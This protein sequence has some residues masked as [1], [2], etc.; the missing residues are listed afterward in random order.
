MN[1]MIVKFTFAAN[2]TTSWRESHLSIRPSNHFGT[3]PLAS[4][5]L[6]VLPFFP[7]HWTGRS[8]PTWTH[9]APDRHWIGCWLKPFSAY[10]P[11][12]DGSIS[13]RDLDNLSL[14]N[15][16]GSWTTCYLLGSFIHELA[17]KRVRSIN[18]SH[19][20]IDGGNVFLWGPFLIKL[21]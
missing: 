21:H 14:K 13:L 7:P 10:S 5:S 9:N 19:L 17:F 18:Y 20:S 6:D 3:L 16:G 15:E 11:K 8:T 12:I 1:T 2:A 4:P